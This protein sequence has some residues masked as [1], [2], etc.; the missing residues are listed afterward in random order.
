MDLAWQLGTLLELTGSQRTTLR[1][2]V[3]DM[4]FPVIGEATAPGVATIA[5]DNT[6]D[7]RNAPTARWVLERRE[8]L[9]QDDVARGTP[10]PPQELIDS[11]GVRAQMLAPVF[12]GERVIGWISVHADAPRIWKSTEIAALRQT[13]VDIGHGLDAIRDEVESRFGRLL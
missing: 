8:I 7:Q 6:L 13:S 1:L 5:D 12:D 11:Y 3:S 2:D 9:V 4:N 10:R